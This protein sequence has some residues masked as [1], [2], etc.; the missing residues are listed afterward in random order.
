MYTYIC[1]NIY[2]DLHFEDPVVVCICI[3]VYVYILPTARISW[4]T[5]ER[6]SVAG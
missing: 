2:C 3:Y 4:F 6:N 5:Y 1:K